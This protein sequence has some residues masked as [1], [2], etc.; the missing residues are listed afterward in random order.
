MKNRKILHPFLRIFLFVSLLLL[1]T[2][3]SSIAMFYY[4][5][6]ITEPEGMSKASWPE[7]FTENFSLWMEND[8]GH[9]KIEEIGL[10]RLDEYGLWLQVLDEEG[11]EVLCHNKPDSYPASYSAPELLSLRTS[12]FTQGYTVF[13]D[14]FE[15][16]GEAWCYLIGFPY[17]IGKRLLYYNGENVERLSPWLRSTILFLFCA[18]ILFTICYGFWLT[19]HL[20]K[21]AA[22]IETISMRSYTPLAEKGLFSKIYQALNRMNSEIRSS[23][24]A[25]QNTERIRREWITNITHD[26]KTPLSP[27]RGYAELLME[28]PAPDGKTM[29]EYGEIIL[30]NVTYTEKLINDLKLTWQ[31]DAGTVPFH[32]QTI[33]FIY[34]LK[35]TVIDIINDPAFAGRSIAFESDIQDFSY[36]F[37]PDLLRRAIH[38]LIINALT[39]NPPETKVT[40]HVPTVSQEELA[41][42]IIDNG[43]GLSD[44]EQ[45]EL[46][47]RYYRGTSTKEKPEGSGL[48]LAIAKQIIT[49]HGGS[50]TVESKQGEGT[51]FTITL[52]L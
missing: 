41:L 52:P 47:N 13:A 48:G 37:D 35:E 33:R 19:G 15:D 8:N 6:G 28:S 40:I 45:A 39:H 32:P 30:K 36:Y 25:K 16:S 23:D 49:L 51:C 43:N 1:I 9:I 21:I 31:F 17:A 20:G 4:I 24:K 42:Y 34:F 12:A 50:I 10:E 27:I 22:G 46:F 18:V 2:V 11:R 3:I 44:E 38:N 26:L 29:R 14:S 5:F 7:I